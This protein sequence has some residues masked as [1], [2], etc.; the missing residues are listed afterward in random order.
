MT[1]DIDSLIESILNDETV[2][3]ATNGLAEEFAKFKAL[4]KMGLIDKD[5]MKLAQ[6]ILGIPTEFDIITFDYQKLTTPLIIVAKPSV[7]PKIQQELPDALPA[8]PYTNKFPTISLLSLEKTI[9]ALA[10]AK[11]PWMRFTVY[12]HRSYSDMPSKAKYVLNKLVELYGEAGRAM[13]LKFFY[14]IPKWSEYSGNDGDV[15][16]ILCHAEKRLGLAE[17]DEC[18]DTDWW[19]YDFW[20]RSKTIVTLSPQEVN[21]I[22]VKY[23]VPVVFVKSVA[24]AIARNAR[25]DVYAKSFNVPLE[26]AQKVIGEIRAMFQSNPHV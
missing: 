1:E 4:A 16:K 26:V 15:A 7:F 13:I 23:N 21:K 9:N 12:V 25:V 22:A 20:G 3:D 6:D 2:S 10:N 19:K 14:L 8:D 11:V 18:D 17:K 24:N 5:Q